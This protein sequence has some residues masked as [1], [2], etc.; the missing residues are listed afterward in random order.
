MDIHAPEG[1]VHSLKDFAMH[2]LIVTIGILIALGLEGVREMVSAHRLV[3][4][5]R[6]NFRGEI[7]FDH[8]HMTLEME[9]VK[10][11]NSLGKKLIAD[12]PGLAAKPEEMKARVDAIEAQGY[13]FS[14]SS[15][16]AALSSGALAHMTSAEV[17]RYAAFDFIVHSYVGQQGRLL[18]QERELK[19][20]V[21]S[22]QRFGPEE[23]METDEKLREFEM[24]TDI[25]LNVGRQAQDTFG[26]ALSGK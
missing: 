23:M 4:E 22:R 19:A 6:E 3:V 14:S 20:Y 15:W 26:E 12:L 11:M 24:E 8:E 2:I 5:A 16:A 10:K 7:A 18:P 25:M 9:N 1:P 13:F 21:E 17:N